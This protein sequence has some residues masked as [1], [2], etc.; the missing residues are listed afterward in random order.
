MRIAEDLLQKLWLSSVIGL[1]KAILGYNPEREHFC[2]IEGR[3]LIFFKQFAAGHSVS[4]ACFCCILYLKTC[5]LLSHI[6]KQGPTNPALFHLVRD[7]KQVCL[8]VLKVM[9]SDMHK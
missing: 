2:F 3:A 8:S 5:I 6:K 4:T 9:F 1:G 7:V